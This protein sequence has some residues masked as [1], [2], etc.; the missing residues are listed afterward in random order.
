MLVGRM[1]KEN[2]DVSRCTV[3]FGARWLDA[4]ETLTAVTTPTIDLLG[5]W[6]PG[7]VPFWPDDSIPNVELPPDPTPLLLDF[8]AALPGGL[9]VQLFLSAGTAGNFYRVSF[10]GT[11][12]SGRAQTVELIMNIKPPPGG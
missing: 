11:G 8:A 6:Q 1:F 12:S 4:G 3:D 10:I 7:P 9:L 2:T 5:A